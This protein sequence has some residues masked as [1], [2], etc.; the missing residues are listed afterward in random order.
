[1]HKLLRDRKKDVSTYPGSGKGRLGLFPKEDKY[2]VSLKI[3]PIIQAR[4]VYRE[5]GILDKMNSIYKV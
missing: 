4:K 2:K 5:K 1:M 3:C